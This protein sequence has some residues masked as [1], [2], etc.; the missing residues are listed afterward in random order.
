MDALG[1]EE[2]MTRQFLVMDSWD[3]NMAGWDDAENAW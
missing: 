3:S 2:A 1:E